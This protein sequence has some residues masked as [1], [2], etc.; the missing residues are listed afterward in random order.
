LSRPEE[1]FRTPLTP[2]EPLPL[3]PVEP[4]SALPLTPVE[5]FRPFGRL[6]PWNHLLTLLRLLGGEKREGGAADP[7]QPR[8]R[9]GSCGVPGSRDG[10]LAELAGPMRT[11]QRKQPQ[12]ARDAFSRIMEL[13]AGLSRESRPR[14]LY[15]TADTLCRIGRESGASLRPFPGVPSPE[16]S[17]RAAFS[18]G[19][20]EHPMPSARACTTPIPGAAR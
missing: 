19:S 6:P 14:G 4:F 10:R 7:V 15:L 5:P 17:T 20:D 12:A 16:S 13:A 11:H 18:A 8:G 3:T 1:I 9:V 2:V